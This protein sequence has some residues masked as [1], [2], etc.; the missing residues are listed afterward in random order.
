MKTART[1]FGEKLKSISKSYTAFLDEVLS[2]EE[3]E[4]I[5]HLNAR[6]SVILTCVYDVMYGNLIDQ[7]SALRLLRS[8]DY[9]KVSSILHIPKKLLRSI[10]FSPESYAEVIEYKDEELTDDLSL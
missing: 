8:L 5:P 7:T 6:F 3:R 2:A 1:V 9:E 10:V 4:L